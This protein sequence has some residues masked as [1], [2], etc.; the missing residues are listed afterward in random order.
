MAKWCKTFFC[1]SLEVEFRQLACLV[2]LLILHS[3]RHVL[4]QESWESC[5]KNSVSTALLFFRSNTKL[6]F[7]TSIILPSL[8]TAIDEK[9]KWNKMDGGGRESRS[10]CLHKMILRRKEISHHFV[11]ATFHWMDQREREN[12]HKNGAKIAS[13]LLC[14]HCPDLLRNF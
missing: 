9:N 5:F 13:S 12:I 3:C 2:F 6:H 11:L 1:R 8:H 10:W 4:S 14:T 7:S